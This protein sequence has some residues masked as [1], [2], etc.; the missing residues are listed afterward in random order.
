MENG[1]RAMAKSLGSSRRFLFV[2]VGVSLSA[3][4]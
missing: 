1:S 2:V 4:N 3:L